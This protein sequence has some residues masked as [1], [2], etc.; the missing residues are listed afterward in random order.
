MMRLF[1]ALPLPAPLRQRL[2]LVQFLLPMPRRVDPAMMHLTLSFLGEVPGHVAEDVHHAL[3]A[4]R[5]PPLALTLAGLGL[6]GGA[7]PRS[8]HAVVAPDPGLAR[9][10]RKVDQ[11]VRR[12]GAVPEARRFLPHI[13]LGRFSPL[14]GDA[15][16][17]LERAVAGGAGLGPE[18][19]SVAEFALYR[20]TL[21]REGAHY[22]A[23]ETYPLA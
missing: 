21:G 11:A 10:Q 20:S 4:I 17:R 19:F 1:V 6:F 8:A 22:E 16:L 15:A 3:A 14:T 18:P 5:H 12:A 2:N 23:L 7:Q 9:L 13:T